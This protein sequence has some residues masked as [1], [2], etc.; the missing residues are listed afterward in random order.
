MKYIFHIK[1]ITFSKKKYLKVTQ[2]CYL[3]QYSWTLKFD[4][5][6]WCD[7]FATTGL[8]TL[9][10]HTPKVQIQFYQKP[11]KSVPDRIH[12]SNSQIEIRIILMSLTSLLRNS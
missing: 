10:K 8:L 6:R 3:S 12:N 11:I 9:L 1:N 2:M 7:L 5:R 4:W